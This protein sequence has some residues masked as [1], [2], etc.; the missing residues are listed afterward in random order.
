[1]NVRILLWLLDK[2]LIG[3]KKVG[4]KKVGEKWLNWKHLVGGKWLIL[5]KVTRPLFFPDYFSPTNWIEEVKGIL[6]SVL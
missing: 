4:E 5:S 6:M 1:M 2:Y 3:E